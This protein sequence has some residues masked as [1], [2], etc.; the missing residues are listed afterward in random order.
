MKKSMKSHTRKSSGKPDYKGKIEIFIEFLVVDALVSYIFYRSMIPFVLILFLYPK[1][2]KYRRRSKRDQRRKELAAQF[3]ESIQS[4]ST[5]LNAGYS[6]ENAF[7]EAYG[8]MKQTYGEDAQIVREY[9]TIAERLK[10]NEAIE[11]IVAD[12]ASRSGVEDIRDFSDVFSAAKRSGGDM[13]KI[14]RRASGNISEKIEVK[15]EIDTLMSSKKY[16]QRIMEL[17]PFAIIAY[18]SLVSPGFLDSLYHNVVGVAVMT[19]CL[20]IYAGGFY[21][22]E[23]IM[24]IE[25]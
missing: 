19:A 15:R 21:L 20:G 4:V 12:F 6:V 7:V 1:Y 3:R 25:V 9:R 24:K 16:E 22:A 14:I 11:V 5:A 18:L 8:D 17:V 13:G 10:N 23:K 2:R